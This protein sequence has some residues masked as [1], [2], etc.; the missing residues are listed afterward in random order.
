MFTVSLREAK[1]RSNPL[2][3]CFPRCI[4]AEC[5]KRGRKDTKL[6]KGVYEN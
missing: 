6:I 5:K 4:L 3:D 1:R 2:K